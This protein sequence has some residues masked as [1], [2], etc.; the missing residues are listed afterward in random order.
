MQ[1]PNQVL[2]AID[3]M[4]VFRKHVA[5]KNVRGDELVGGLCVVLVPNLFV[6]AVDEGFV[7]LSGH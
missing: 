2:V 6:Q 4:L 5:G 1:P 7:L 3:A